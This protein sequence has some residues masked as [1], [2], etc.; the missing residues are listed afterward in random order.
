M[1]AYVVKSNAFRSGGIS[2]FVA[3]AAVLFLIAVPTCL[4][5]INTPLD[6]HLL[7][8]LSQPPVCLDH[9]T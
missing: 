6:T 7:L 9:A 1:H 2:F 4:F 8:K 3:L 5:T